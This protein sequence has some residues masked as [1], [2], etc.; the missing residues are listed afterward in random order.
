MEGASARL[1]REV[2]ARARKA[3]VDLAKWRKDALNRAE[4]V[5]CQGKKRLA[6][7][8]ELAPIVIEAVEI[9]DEGAGPVEE[10]TATR[11]QRRPVALAR[12]DW[13]AELRLERHHRFTHGRLRPTEL[14]RRG[15]KTTGADHGIDAP[16]LLLGHDLLLI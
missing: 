11:R 12:K 15:S 1:D 7:I 9:C 10:G 8:D 6:A 2:E 16:Q 13:K 4:M 5:N 14:R 3:G